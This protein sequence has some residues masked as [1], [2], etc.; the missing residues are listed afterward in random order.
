VTNAKFG[1]GN[2]GRDLPETT[3]LRGKEEAVASQLAKKSPEAQPADNGNP[4][5]DTMWGFR[6]GNKTLRGW[7]ATPGRSPNE[8]NEA[9]DEDAEDTG[10]YR[11]RHAMWFRIGHEISDREVV[12]KKTNL[13][14]K[15]WYK[16]MQCCRAMLRAQVERKIYRE[17]VVSELKQH[18]LPDNIA[19][20]KPIR[21]CLRRSGVLCHTSS[22]G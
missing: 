3:R 11:Q 7:P 9:V 5:Q 22:K 4:G 17:E 18:H 21:R 2:V 19:D 12:A 20:P 10:G 13:R 14:G 15:R 16:K 1:C 6:V 8:D